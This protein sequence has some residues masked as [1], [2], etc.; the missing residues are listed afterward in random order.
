MEFVVGA[1]PQV[2]LPPKHS[3]GNGGFVEAKVLNV[4]PPRRKK[5][6]LPD[7]NDRRQANAPKDP[8]GGRVMVLLVPEGYN[9]PRDIAS[10]KY[11]T[12]LRFAPRRR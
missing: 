3:A 11:R 1:T 12:F 8:L 2:G 5:Q 6:R 7:E 9:I 4:R 10:G